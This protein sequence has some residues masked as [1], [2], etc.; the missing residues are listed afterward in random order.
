LSGTG[1]IRVQALKRR[2][3]VMIAVDVVAVIAAVAMMFAYT[4]SDDS[5]YL[6]GFAAAIV[7]GLG[8]QVWLILGIVSERNSLKGPVA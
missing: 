6:I 5:R 7:V 2:L 4:N 3:M 8:A 1:D